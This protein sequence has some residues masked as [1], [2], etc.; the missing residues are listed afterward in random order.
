MYTGSGWADSAWSPED[1]TAPA[2]H[3]TVAL[4]RWGLRRLLG[5]WVQVGAGLPRLQAKGG[6]CAV[7]ALA[8][9][10]C[11]L[12]GRWLEAEVGPRQD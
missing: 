11:S 4:A 9:H 5:G 6:L 2:G 3:C 7:A 12:S 8:D 10:N 1:G